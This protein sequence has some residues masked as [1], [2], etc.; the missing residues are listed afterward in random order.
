MQILKYI[1][2]YRFREKLPKYF[3]FRY[4][5]NYFEWAGQPLQ[6]FEPGETKSKLNNTNDKSCNNRNKT[7]Q[8]TPDIM[9]LF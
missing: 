6:L 3:Y 7:R 5:T 8:W 1:C 2:M 9:P 4:F